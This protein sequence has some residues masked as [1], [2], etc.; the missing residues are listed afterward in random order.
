MNLLLL[1][2]FVLLAMMMQYARLSTLPTTIFVDVS[3]AITIPYMIIFVL[4]LPIIMTLMFVLPVF[5]TLEIIVHI[6]IKHFIHIK[7]TK[8]ECYCKNI[9]SLHKQVYSHLMVMRC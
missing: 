8:K 6:P 1:L 4:I 5:L 2:L 3:Y 7:H 9:Y